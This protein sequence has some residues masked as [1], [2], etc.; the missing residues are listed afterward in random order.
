M[1]QQARMTDQ[2]QERESLREREEKVP[3]SIG[4]PIHWHSTEQQ[5]AKSKLTPAQYAHLNSL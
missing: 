4:S 1:L 2:Q 5:H 3:D